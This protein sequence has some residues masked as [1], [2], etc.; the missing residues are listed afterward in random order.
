[1]DVREMGCDGVDGIALVEDR[2]S[3]EGSY[4]HGNVPLSLIKLE[5]F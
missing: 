3:V 2:G 5:I 4:E 1:M